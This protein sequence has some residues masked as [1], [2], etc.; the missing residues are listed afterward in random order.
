SPPKLDVVGNV[1][2]ATTKL[3]FPYIREHVVAWLEEQWPATLPSP[4][5]SSIPFPEQALLHARTHNIPQ[6][7]KR[8]HYELIRSSDF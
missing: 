8:A 3:S 2:H 1:L 4:N 7:M 5:S 6:I